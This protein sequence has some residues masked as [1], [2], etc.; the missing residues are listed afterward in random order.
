MLVHAR[1]RLVLYLL[2][3][4]HR[5]ARQR[6]A[7][8]RNAHVSSVFQRPTGHIP[9]CVKDE[10]TPPLVGDTGRVHSFGAQ[11]IV[12]LLSSLSDLSSSLQ[13]ATSSFLPGNVLS[14]GLAR[15]APVLPGTWTSLGC[16]T[17]GVLFP[18]LFTQLN[19]SC[20]AILRVEELWHQ[21]NLP[22]PPA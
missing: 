5:D 14:H 11:I 7:Y 17:Y 19:A 22:T 3:W 18:L 6:E 16:Y 9:P 21:P 10:S 12:W 20:T 15:R 2:L 4:A 13:L 1:F 8:I